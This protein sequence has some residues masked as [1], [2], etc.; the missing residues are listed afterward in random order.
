[1]KHYRPKLLSDYVRV[2][3]LLCPVPIVIEH[4]KKHR[5]QQDDEAVDYLIE[6]LFVPSVEVD[7]FK[8]MALSAMLLDKFWCERNL[9]R[10]RQGVFSYEKIWYLA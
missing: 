8:K 5:D 7:N 3:Y 9:F 10:N 2:V 1:M 4:T 6:K